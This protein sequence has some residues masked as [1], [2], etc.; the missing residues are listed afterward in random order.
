LIAGFI[1]RAVTDGLAVLGG[2]VV[3]G[4]MLVVLAV[5]LARPRNGG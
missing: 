1:V 5:L 2:W 4:T 3:F